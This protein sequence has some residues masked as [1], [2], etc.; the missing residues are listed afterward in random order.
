MMQSCFFLH[1]Y[2]EMSNEQLLEKF[3]PA[4]VKFNPEFK[5]DWVHKI[6]YASPFRGWDRGTI[7]AVEIGRREAGLMK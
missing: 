3:I 7:F 5:R 4:F 2:F 1:E 6:N